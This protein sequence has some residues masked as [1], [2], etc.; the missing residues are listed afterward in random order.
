MND[1]DG[2][3]RKYKLFEI[4]REIYIIYENRLKLAC[5]KGSNIWKSYRNSLEWMEMYWKCDVNG[6][7]CAGNIWKWGEH[8]YRTLELLAQYFS[9]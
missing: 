3:K 4:C 1:F 6:G 2:S 7:K 8:I 5:G 9:E